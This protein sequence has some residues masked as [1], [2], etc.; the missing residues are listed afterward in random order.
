M[1]PTADP[2]TDSERDA[3]RALFA[4]EMFVPG[5][6]TIRVAEMTAEELERALGLDEREP[7][8]EGA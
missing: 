4:S 5:V 7:A 6:G 1:H 3:I 8:A 2:L